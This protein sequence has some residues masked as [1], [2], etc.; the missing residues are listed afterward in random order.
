MGAIIGGISGVF[1]L[2]MTYLGTHESHK[3]TPIQEVRME[4]IIGIS[5]GQVSGPADPT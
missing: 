1:V 4:G 5:Y 2:L 3:A